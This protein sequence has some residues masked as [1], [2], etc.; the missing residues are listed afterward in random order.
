MLIDAHVHI[1]SN[2]IFSRQLWE[3]SSEEWKRRWIRKIFEEYK[4]RKIFILRDGGD[5]ISVSQMAR[6]V[7]KEEGIIYKSPIFA[8][9]KKGH[10]GSFLG[11]SLDDIQSFKDKSRELMSHMPDH[12][13]II[14]TGIVNFNHY[15]DVGETAFNFKEL[16]YMVAFARFNNIPVMVHANG[17]E[18]VEMAVR[19]GVTTIEHGYFISEGALYGMAE[20]GIIWVPTLSPLGNILSP[21]IDRFINQRDVIQ[22]IYEQQLENVLRAMALGVK[23]ALGSDSGAYGVDHGSG[24]MDEIAHFS[25]IG[26]SQTDMEKCMKNGLEALAL[27]SV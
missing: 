16:K 25:K 10:Y 4:K 12:L 13:K 3:I 21:D 9:H 24:L 7:A 20:K 18:G 8:F 5:G 6:E 22:K 15:G 14:L 27:K 23:V 11:Q 2:N 1:A 17:V 19:A 26:L